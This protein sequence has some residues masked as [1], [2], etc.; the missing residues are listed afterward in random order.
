MTLLVTRTD[1]NAGFDLTLIDGAGRAITIENDPASMSLIAGA[2]VTA[3]LGFQDLLNRS[4]PPDTPREN[5]LRVYFEDEQAYIGDQPD[6]IGAPFIWPT[7]YTGNI[8]IPDNTGFWERRF[9]RHAGDGTITLGDG[10]YPATR[11]VSPQAGVVDIRG[12]NVG[13]ATIQA[14]FEAKNKFIRLWNMNLLPPVGTPL[15]TLDDC[16]VDLRDISVDLATLASG[17]IGTLAL[18]NGTVFRVTASVRD[19]LFALSDTLATQCF[20]FDNGSSVKFVAN[21]TTKRIKFTF[22]NDINAIILDA[23]GGLLTGTYVTGPAKGTGEGVDIRR[24]SR[25]KMNDDCRFTDLLVGARVR[26]LSEIFFEDGQVN[27]CTYGLRRELGKI[28]YSLTDV[29]FSGNDHNTFDAGNVYGVLG[30]EG[31]A[32]WTFSTGTTTVAA[33]STVY[34]GQGVVNASAANIRIPIPVDC[35]IGDLYHRASGGPGVGQ[36]YTI[37]LY[38]NGVATALTA[39]C[40]GTAMAVN[41]TDRVQLSAGGYLGIEIIASAGASVREHAVSFKPYV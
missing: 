25:L 20:D 33:G 21:T 35:T 19:V 18:V 34:M 6:T 3:N 14:E 31:L 13:G 38:V 32:P 37:T 24:L 41:T 5:Y 17:S 15:F 26:D 16:E 11:I 30:L 28:V 40:T 8:V 9:N 23:S 2:V 12:Q 4:S 1:L 27:T 10:N 36:T 39:Q 29:I 22:D 7:W